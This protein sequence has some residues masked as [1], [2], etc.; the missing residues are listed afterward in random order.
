MNELIEKLRKAEKRAREL[1]AQRDANEA[2][3]EKLYEAARKTPEW[4]EYCK[5]TGQV[6]RYNYNDV[7][8]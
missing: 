2:R 4:D 7:I 5:S 6:A 8:C 3:W 1:A